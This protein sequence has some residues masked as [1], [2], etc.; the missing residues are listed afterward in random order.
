M[1]NI[2]FSI[3]LLLL[4]TPAISQEGKSVLMVVDVQEKFIN[5]SMQ[6]EDAARLV[7]NINRAIREARPKEV[8]FIQA[9]YRVLSVSLKGIK[10]ISEGFSDLSPMLDIKMNDPVFRKDKPSAF[11][12]EA[13]VAHLEKQHVN[14]IYLVGLFAGECIR[15]TA[16]DGLDRGYHIAVVGEGVASKDPRKLEKYLKRLYNN[17]VEIL[18][19]DAF[20]KSI[21][22]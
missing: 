4:G 8:I 16:L 6:Q 3:F 14:R 21:A 9:E 12:N 20:C 11:T 17:G 13:L 10:V 15:A 2:L 5:E 22:L 18:S 7:N 1:K 19:I